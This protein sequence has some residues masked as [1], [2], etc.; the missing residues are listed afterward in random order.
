MGSNLLLFIALL[1]ILLVSISK[2]CFAG[3]SI[4]ST[5]FL[6]D[7]DT[8]VSSSGIF[9]MGFFRP[10]NNSL[11]HY[12]GIWYKQLPIRTV[13]W[14]ANRDA[15]ITNISSVALQMLST[16]RLAL[17]DANN[18]LFW[19]TNSSR[20]IQNNPPVAKL[21]DSGNLV[22]TDAN[23]NFLWQSFDHPTD[24]LLP[25][26]II[27]KNFITG[28][29]ITLSAWKTEDNPGSGEYK[30][31]LESTGYPEM[32][33]R[34][35]GEEVYRSGPWNGLRWS[36]IPGLAKNEGT[37]EMSVIVNTTGVFVSYKV[38]NISTLLRIVV[39]SSGYVEINL[40]VDGTQ[41]EGW[42]TIRNVPT[43]G[44]DRYGYC[45]AYGSCNYDNY[46]VCAC[47]NKFLAKS[48]AEWSRSEF[49]G[50][51]VRKTPLSCQN[52]SSSDG[53]FRYS[54]I[55]LPD[56]K[57][58]WFNTSMDLYECEQVCLKN[59]NCTA[60][61]SLDISN[62]QNGCLL[63]FGDL[64]DIKELPPH[65]GQDLFIRVASSDLGM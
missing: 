63:W 9:E 36:G 18:A 6:K 8:I 56:T 65:K 53:F 47:L 59:C 26:M 14:V 3:D 49:S 15:P 52:G 50:G 35:G 51:C 29:E 5:H 39:S 45:G 57:F 40:W 1:I 37:S 60:Y 28:H 43:D 20:L 58:S 31:F 33:L 2:I 23:E 32:I 38:F 17:V 11:N 25:G 27:E 22:I 4:Y 16:G 55:K 61:S 64:V 41:R 12:V 54:D 44:C 7:G 62:G 19:Y 10:N 46:P 13:V 21:L 30:F 48:T 34:N 42:N 24:T